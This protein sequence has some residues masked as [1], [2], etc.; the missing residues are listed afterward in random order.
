MCRNHSHVS[1]LRLGQ[2][3]LTPHGW[4]QSYRV[5]QSLAVQTPTGDD[6]I[7]PPGTIFYVPSRYDADLSP[8]V[9]PP[10]EGPTEQPP[11]STADEPTYT[12]VMMHHTTA[13]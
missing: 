2:V 1:A 10:T 3:V 8:L 11:S 9:I 12:A 5:L 6:A 7:Y 4:M 13:P